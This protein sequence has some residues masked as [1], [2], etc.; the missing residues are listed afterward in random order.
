MTKARRKNPTLSLEEAT[1][2]FRETVQQPGTDSMAVALDVL[3]ENGLT[4][5]EMGSSWVNSIPNTIG[6]SL[7]QRATRAVS[8]GYFQLASDESIGVAWG[9]TEMREGNYDDANDRY[10]PILMIRYLGVLWHETPHRVGLPLPIKMTKAWEGRQGLENQNSL[11]STRGRV[12][13]GEIIPIVALQAWRVS[14]ALKELR[15]QD[16][17]VDSFD[18]WIELREV[19]DDM[20]DAHRDRVPIAGIAT[21]PHAVIAPQHPRMTVLKVNPPRAGDELLTEAQR[22]L[23]ERDPESTQ[24]FQDLVLEQETTVG[25]LGRSFGVPEDAKEQIRRKSTLMDDAFVVGSGGFEVTKTKQWPEERERTLPSHYASYLINGDATGLDD[26]EITT[27]ERYV[28]VQGL[29]HCTGMGEEVWFAHR[30]D[31]G[32]GG[33]VAVFTFASYKNEAPEGSWWQIIPAT[34]KN[35]DKFL[36]TVNVLYRGLVFNFPSGR[37][38]TGEAEAFEWSSRV[39][40]RNAAILKMN[41]DVDSVGKLVQLFTA[42]DHA[43]GLHGLETPKNL[44]EIELVGPGDMKDMKENPPKRREV[45][46]Q[47]QAAAIRIRREFVELLESAD[48]GSLDV[49]RDLLLDN[50]VKLADIAHHLALDGESNNESKEM[51]GWAGDFPSGTTGELVLSSEKDVA[52]PD[53]MAVGWT[54]YRL[55]PATVRR[56]RADNR[57]AMPYESEIAIDYLGS[58]W[59]ISHNGFGHFKRAGKFVLAAD[60]NHMRIERAVIDPEAFA[61]MDG[62]TGIGT[63]GGATLEVAERRTIDMAWQ[64]AKILKQHRGLGD[65]EMAAMISHTVKPT[66]SKEAPRA[67]I[68]P[69]RSI[70]NPNRFR[71]NPPWVTGA[72][73]DAFESIAEQVRADWLPKLSKVRGLGDELAGTLAEYGCGAY[74]CV[75]P[76]LDPVVVLKVTTDETEADFAAKIA[77]DLVRPICVE[78][79]QAMSLDARHEHRT[80][81]LLWREAADDVGELGKVLGAAAKD[82]VDAQHELAKLAYKAL[83]E[84][85]LDDARIHLREW[86]V[87]VDKMGAVRELRSLATGMLEVYKKQKVFF[88]DI[89]PG[90]LGR[91][92]RGGTAGEWVITDPGHVAVLR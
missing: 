30:S 82:V 1:A 11:V 56:I 15:E 59:A 3:E 35:K 54:I 84:K 80:I 64:I 43:D 37:R 44:F 65:V 6:N 50:G 83:F 16:Y 71:P 32:P 48:P 72:L 63:F 2:R 89:H 10:K 55:N 39:A 67:L 45:S 12:W 87:A 5:E 78:Y 85:R 27:I 70:P 69:A 31:L 66:P 14:V 18:E 79:Y 19:L 75:L 73:A 68:N 88:G 22:L 81:Y 36:A 28:E 21:P 20:A 17:T 53:Y 91:V 9:I 33:D 13:I 57:E 92:F 24:I 25:A 40:W 52:A 49:A 74:G 76:T 26:D 62:L 86:H 77:A 42:G 23:L 60:D 58:S 38:F 90:N 46:Q 61:D 4:L 41:R 47:E 7:A 29:G 51:K 8:L 34:S